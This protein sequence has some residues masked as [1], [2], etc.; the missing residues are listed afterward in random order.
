V[1]GSFAGCLARTVPIQAI[2]LALALVLSAHPSRGD[3]VTIFAAASTKDAVENL[4]KRFRA[5][6]GGAVRTVF[7]ASSTLAKQI[8]QG[9]PA[10]LYLSAD[11]AWMD[12]LAQRGAIDAASRVDLLGNCLVL[13]VPSD[14]GAAPADPGELGAAALGAFLDA[15]LTDDRPLAIA[16]PGHVPAGLYAEAALET[17]G[18][19]QGLAERTAR[20]ADVRVALALVDRGEAPVGIVYRTDALI[21][22]R[23]RV[24]GWFPA[25]SHPPIVYSLALVAA[26]A[27]DA[28]RRFYDLLRSVDSAAVFRSYGFRVLPEPSP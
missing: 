1:H 28:A 13:I 26:P 27:S 24:V 14:G 11:P 21:S 15:T 6:G 17:L 20:T 8:A 10:D 25:A 9:A 3:E 5:A 19:W 16:D 18:L 2:G 7:A 22:S 23:V 4:A 12:Q